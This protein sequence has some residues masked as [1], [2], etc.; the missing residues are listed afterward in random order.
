MVTWMKKID[1]VTREKS[2]LP[3]VGMLAAQEAELDACRGCSDVVGEK[4]RAGFMGN[5]ARGVGCS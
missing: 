1:F 4:T 3:L 2:C 5:E